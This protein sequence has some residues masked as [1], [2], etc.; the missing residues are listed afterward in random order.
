[1][2]VC[3][4]QIFLLKRMKQ[5]ELKLVFK[6]VIRHFQREGAWQVVILVDKIFLELVRCHRGPRSM[7]VGLM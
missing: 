1:M 7:L 2:Q 3:L 6:P 4:N 5:R